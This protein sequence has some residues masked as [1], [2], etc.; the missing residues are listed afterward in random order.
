[1]R[2]VLRATASC[3]GGLESGDVSVIVAIVG[4]SEAS[5]ASMVQALD[6]A[7]SDWILQ[8]HREPPEHADVIVCDRAIEPRAGAIVFDEADDLI[9]SITAR[10]GRT[11][12]TI[13]VSAPSGGLGATSVALHLAAGFA[14]RGR[15]T[16]FV[17]L[18]PE[19]GARARLGLDREAIPVSPVPVASGFKLLPSL[20]A[21]AAFERVVVDAPRSSIE[22]AGPCDTGVLVCSPTLEGAR[23]TRSLLQAHQDIQW[24]VVL[25]R[26]GPGGETTRAQLE[27]AIGHRAIELPCSAALRDAEDETRL[28]KSGWTRWSRGIGRLVAQ[29]D[30]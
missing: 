28:L 10:V 9:G 27:R 12:R 14:A 17:D 16:G 18:D 15:Q 24:Q 26:I 3:D 22:R 13:L 1:M 19:R 6:A 29:L 4:S 7:P 21:H 5:R 2:A 30:A 25:N 20:D 23:R 11:G 8:L